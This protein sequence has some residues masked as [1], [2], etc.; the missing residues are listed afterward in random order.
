MK[1]EPP[2]AIPRHDGRVGTRL[3]PVIRDT[4]V[5]V[6]AGVLTLVC[7]YVILRYAL[8]ALLTA[9]I[10]GEAGVFI[11]SRPVIINALVVA[12]GIILAGLI[13]ARRAGVSARMRLALSY[14]A[15]LVAAGFAVLFGVYVVLR[16]IP[17]YPLTAA[18]PGGASETVLSRGAI[19]NAVVGA[20]GIILAVLAVIGIAGGW[21]LAGWVLRPLERIN[22]AARIAATGRLEHRIRLTGRNDEF[23]QL[24]DTFD[25]MLGRLHDAFTTQERFAANASHELRT[26]LTVMATMLDVARRNPDGQDYATLIERLTITN[27]RAIGLVEAL[28]RLADANA[29]TAVS[30]PVDL[31]VIARDAVEA[32]EAEASALDVTI[33]TRLES[34]ATNGDATLLTQLA[35]NLVQNAIRHNHAGG[36]VWISTRQD[37]SRAAVSLRIENTGAV[38]T[39]ELA[40]QLSDPFQRGGGRITRPDSSSRGYGLGLTLVARITEVHQG[41]LTIDPR[42]GGGLAVTVELPDAGRRPD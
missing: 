7:V 18:N 40:A 36:S 6:G 8:S 13:V 38:Y 23:R 4:V 32:S 10:P 37:R 20:S 25:T 27:A 15:F 33:D 24:A 35:A 29:V 22:E 17:N 30:E 11:A 42:D 2:A 5:L 14:A 41:T 39:P 26:P 28:L 31:E 34:A 9:P 3:R 19:L 16:Y 12:V 21:V 1:R